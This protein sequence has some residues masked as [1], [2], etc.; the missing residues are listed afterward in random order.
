M[1]AATKPTSPKLDQ[2]SLEVR[3]LVRTALSAW[4]M[5]APTHRA[6]LIGAVAVMAVGAV[7]STGLPL[8]SGKL[9]DRV[10]HGI[11]TG[12]DRA[13]TL[14][15]VGYLLGVIAGL[16]LLRELLQV[17]RR[18]LVENTCTRIERHTTVR[19]VAH[20]L[21]ADLGHLTH[22]KVGT[23]QGKIFRSV[24]GF[25]R[26][27][28][29]SFL[30]FFPAVVVGAFAVVTA[31]VKQP[32]LG[33]AILGVIPV[34]LGLTVWQLVSQKRVRQ[35]LLRVNEDMD[36]TVVE[37]LG[38]LEYVRV[39]NTDAQEVRRVAKAAEQKRSKELKH[40]VAMSFFGAGKAVVEGVFHVGVLALAS[41]LAITGHITFGDIL[42]FSML[43]LGAMAPLNEVHR[44]LDEGH[45]ASLR[46]LDLQELLALPQDPSFA[47]P[48][49]T[50]P[51]LDDGQPVVRVDGLRVEYRT[52]DGGRKPAVRDLSLEIF[53]GETIGIAGR[54]G[55]GKSTWL[56]VLM[57]LLHPAAGRVWLKGVPLD[58]VSRETI[59]QLVGYVG[60]N[61]FVF[62][63]TIE[64]NITYGIAKYLPEDVARAAR[65]ACLHDE[66]LAM[67][68]GYKARVAERGGNLSGGQ[69][70]RLALAR[71]F[72][73]DPPVLILDEATSALDAISERVVQQT[74][75]TRDRRRTVIMVAHRLSTFAD[76]DRIFVFDDGRLIE[77]G[78]FDELTAADG[79]FAELVRCS[80]LEQA[81]PPAGEPALPAAG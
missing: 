10:A 9:V 47:T 41:Y 32:W 62:S 58:E 18:Y 56:K 69:K 13:E 61:P 11:Q 22:E 74:I 6:A 35:K 55:C 40:H 79:V 75:G 5:I 50:S 16:V 51:R 39:A 20:I 80:E 71:V 59:G 73:Q 76:A 54:S 70:Q 15:Y 29:L 57:R 38:G 21:R 36:G 30:D 34:S 72:L 44:V 46:V 45:E 66:I 53:P 4:R 25:M 49:H 17:F 37:L 23:L 77:S 14:S 43:F 27:L 19:V 63:G 78:D 81:T 42:T 68:G 33:V 67:P 60:Q 52:P 7:A 12:E 8:L 3:L 28:R 48:T 31:V 64:E 65:M 24:G 26:L 1:T 2:F